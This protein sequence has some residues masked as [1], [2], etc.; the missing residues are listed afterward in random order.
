MGDTNG[1][2][3]ALG[4]ASKPPSSVLNRAPRGNLPPALPVGTV[5]RDRY[6]LTEILEID[7][8][9]TLYRAESLRTGQTVA[10]KIFHEVGRNDRSRIEILRR[11]TPSNRARLELPDSCA[12]VEDC[13][14]ADDGRLFL[15]IELVEAPSVADLL[16]QTPSLAPERALELAIRVG[17]ALEET[18]NLGLLDLRMAP[19]DIIPVTGGDRVKLLRSDALILRRLGLGDQLVAAETPIRDPRY[20]SPE[21]LSGFPATERSAVYRFGVL[22]YELLCGEP[23]FDAA[24]P[25]KL[26]DQQLRPPPRQL[27][28]RHPTLPASLD[29]L[30]SRVIDPDPAARPVGLASILNELWDAECR[31]R[32]ELAPASTNA[33]SPSVTAASPPVRRSPTRLWAL[34]GV[35]IVVIGGVFLAWFHIVGRPTGP[36]THPT[37]VVSP[38][39]SMLVSEPS[40]A[41]EVASPIVVPPSSGPILSRIPGLDSPAVPLPATELLPSPAVRQGG[42]APPSRVGRAAPVAQSTTPAESL[43]PPNTPAPPSPRA[44]TVAAPPVQRNQPAPESLRSGDPTAIIEWLIREEPRPEE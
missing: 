1:P 32:T 23:P 38:P 28:D 24:T 3:S 6:R 34:A 11:P 2:Y 35:P 16:R 4:G 5:L 30:V 21:E 8:V 18:L 22:L 9:A 42:A 36:A 43:S 25:A 40:A 14:L 12:T 7:Q 37:A 26:S 10:V 31:L 29:R 33:A 15:A 41:P 27:R 17:E 44:P 20:V 39:H 19:H 13:D